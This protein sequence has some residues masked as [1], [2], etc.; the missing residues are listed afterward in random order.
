MHG[1]VSVQTP[2]K[3][4]YWIS[5]IDDCTCYRTIYLLHKKSDAFPAFKEFKAFA[6]KQ[7]GYSIKALRDDKGG[8]YM[9]KEMDTWMK[10]HGI[11]REHT[12]PATPQQ[13]GVAERT[14]RIFDEG[15]TCMLNEAKLPG[16]FWGDAL[17]TFVHV[18]NR[19]PSSS[20]KDITP[21][22]A[23]FGQKPPVDHFRVFGCQAYVHVQKNKHRS[24]EAKSRRCIFI[25]YPPDYKGWKVYDPLTQKITIS[26][27]VIFD[28]QTMPGTRT[29]AS[30]S[31]YTPSHLDLVSESGGE[32]S[33]QSHY[34]SP[35]SNND[36]D[37]LTSE[38]DSES[39]P[40]SSPPPSP[41]LSPSI[42]STPSPPSTPTPSEPHHSP[43]PPPAPSTVPSSRPTRSSTRITAGKHRPDWFKVTHPVGS[44]PSRHLQDYRESPPPIPESD[45]ESDGSE[46]D[47]VASQ[48][49]A[50]L[51]KSL[52][53]DLSTEEV[54]EYAFAT[55]TVEPKSMQEAKQR[56][57]WPLWKEAALKE[58]TQMLAHNTWELVSLP[59]GQKPVGS[60]WVF[61]IKENAD[62][63]IERYKA[64]IVA[65]GFSQKPH[66]DY[67]ETFAPVAKFASL[68][69]I[70]AI[71]A[72]EDME[73]HHMDVSS[74]FLNGDLEEDIYMAQ[75]EGFVEPGQ[76]HLVCHLKKS[77]YGLKQSPRQWYQKLHETF[78]SIGFKQCPS[79][80]SIWVWAKDKVKIIIP[81][82]VDDL[83]LA[84]N[85]LSALNELK[86]QLRAKFE[87]RDL[88]ELKYILG[89][90]IK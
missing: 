89:L 20:L 64:R 53:K 61:K 44:G 50:L 16:S 27:D 84:C 72:I 60:K 43:S 68:Q 62:G 67:T 63:S 10:S 45:S 35:L 78:T 70:L 79:D 12:T 54:I 7:T 66:L 80:N 74:A 34:F 65:Q 24:F 29:N 23:W 86:S 26:R 19:S 51:T 38:P 85:N 87:M 28:E 22:E 55:S 71:A 77:L 82:Y 40:P 41:P 15:I 39:S 31:I 56:G 33:Q 75:P 8:E 52:R 36:N 30:D 83:T 25:G 90:E 9:S 69:T 14:N 6:E 1:P 17:G 4:Q 48:D 49:M 58:Y 88:G 76:E 73:L 2:Q 42:P 46:N 13:N 47:Y 5:F 11:L 3:H 57:D 59:K 81:V 37:T 18:L 21:Y 32:Q